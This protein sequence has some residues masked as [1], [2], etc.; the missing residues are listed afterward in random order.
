MDDDGVTAGR[1]IPLRVKVIIEGDQMTIDFSNLSSQVAG[2]YNSGASAGRSCA[3]V[4]F[5]CLTSP[6]LLPI[7]EGSF[8]ALKVILPPGKVVS[9]EK[10]AAVRWWM[11]IPMTIVD[12]IFRALAPAIPDHVI[13]G[14][15]ADI[16]VPYMYGTDQRS[17]RFFIDPMFG[18]PGGGW[19]A[20]SRHD[21]M[22][23]TI[24]IND[25]DTHNTPVEAGE[26]RIPYITEYYRLR[27]DSGGPGRYRGGMGAELCRR[28]LASGFVNSQIERTVYP[29]WGVEGGGAAQPNKIRVRRASGAVEEFPNGKLNSLQ[30]VPGDAV[31][32]SAGGGG[33]FGDALERD[34]A[35]VR[36][37]VIRGYVSLAQAREAYGVVISADTHEIDPVATAARRADLREA[38]ATQA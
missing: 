30:L 25:G 28:M 29:P 9:A 17:G 35:A 33:G 16:V 5:K 8:R 32:I 6:K 12:T 14:H 21:G 26:V 23:A 20:T 31:I 22:S 27:P 36:F 2:Y 37:D 38:R 7:N 24:C 10:P 18:V 4:A 19:G 3:Q 13:A 34:P 15:H 11:T 1:P